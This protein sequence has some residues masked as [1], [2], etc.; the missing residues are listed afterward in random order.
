MKLFC[1]L[2]VL[3]ALAGSFH[4]SQAQRLT[5]ARVADKS[6]LAPL[7]FGTSSV[8]D[9]QGNTYTWQTIAGPTA[10][11]TASL[12]TTPNRID[13][14]TGQV[15]AWNQDVCLAKF[16]PNGQLA[17]VRQGGGNYT[18]QAYGLAADERG[19]VFVAGFNWSRFRFGTQAVADS[20][21]FLA[22][23]D[24]SGNVR[25]AQHLT[26]YPNTQNVSFKTAQLQTDGLG[27]CYLLGYALNTPSFSGQPLT[28]TGHY[29]AFI[30][31]CNEAGQY[32]WVRQLFSSTPI[33]TSQAR[34]IE[35]QLAVDAVGNCTLA[36]TFADTLR[37]GTGG[38]RLMQGASG[39]TFTNT[40]V[41]RYD[42]HGQLLWVRQGSC[43]YVSG[44]TND[45]VGNTY[46]TGYNGSQFGSLS[47][48]VGTLFLVK[49][50]PAGTEQWLRSNWDGYTSGVQT[51]T[52]GNVYV[53]GRHSGAMTVGNYT[54]PQPVSGLFDGFLLSYTGAGDPRWLYGFGGPGSY[55]NVSGLG[56]DDQHNM[57]AVLSSDSLTYIGGQRVPGSFNAS[58][59]A[60]FTQQANR[61]AGTVYL[62]ADGDGRRDSTEIPFPRPVVLTTPTDG[63][64]F[65]H[66]TQLTGAFQSFTGLGPWEVRPAQLPAYYTL[67]APAAGQY[68]GSFGS[69]G[70][71]A[72]TLAFG[73]RP[74]ANQP[75]L[76]VVLTPYGAARPG[77]TTAYR[78]TLENMGTTTVSGTVTLSLDSHFTYVSSTP[79][80]S[81]NGSTISW[82]YSNLAPF[83]RREYNVLLSLPVNAALGT[84]LSSSASALLASDLNPT[85]NTSAATQLI[86]GSF[87]PND[88]TV[89]YSELTPAQV[90]A[91]QPLDYTIRFQNMGTDTAFAVVVRDTLSFS[92]LNLATTQ[93]VAQSHNCAWSLSNNGLLVVHFTSIKLPTRNTDIIRS[94]GFVRFRIQ[95]KLTLQSGE[96]IPNR[97]HIV[98]DY[99]NPVGTNTATTAVLNPTAILNSRAALAWATYPNPATDALHIEAELPVA[100]LVQLQLLD[101]L[102]RS[103]QQRQLLAPAGAFRQTLDRGAQVPGL[104]LLRLT[105]PD[106][107]SSTRTIE[108]K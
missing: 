25:W 35:G 5:W 39:T 60:R 8:T 11:G 104:Y 97:A 21:Y 86:T 89:N 66:E 81:R 71:V 53:S 38:P 32:E 41:I 100:G 55:D 72:D 56:L 91:G 4:R 47:G 16:R 43:S 82:T 73:L 22:R 24:T 62:D 106:G 33:G 37:L 80:G 78:L 40:A 59:L 63:Q 90:T 76:R 19:N 9:R 65:T 85:N 68:N 77:F 108:R 57:Y 30:A 107:R 46:L 70:Q 87:D 34:S 44:V 61:L 105:L 13:P 31:K 6:E 58:V 29:D 1:R 83:A 102:G 23:V 52:D 49:Y 69:Y 27:N 12:T 14:Q 75:D 36:C 98:F 51:D 50:D 45:A 15:T 18:N 88:I 92:K 74:V 84:T 93:M 101:V 96:I 79:S 103:V 94:Q 17:W 64:F 10:I 99:N 2:L 54:L 28:V 48:A 95:P 67:T 42:R 7:Y 3:L 26:S 20:G